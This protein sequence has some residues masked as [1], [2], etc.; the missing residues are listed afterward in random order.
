MGKGRKDE[1]V[2]CSDRQLRK[3]IYDL[4]KSE[5][6]ITVNNTDDPDPAGLLQIAR[7][8]FVDRVEKQAAERRWSPE[9]ERRI[10]GCI[11]QL[12]K[13]EIAPNCLKTETITKHRGKG[14]QS[15]VVRTQRVKSREEFRQVA[16]LVS[17]VPQFR[18]R[19]AQVSAGGNFSP[20]LSAASSVF[21]SAQ[22]SA[23]A[24]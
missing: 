2:G 4:V 11:S 3:T 5:G 15:E 21:S 16:V 20:P 18:T 17:L 22:S 13:F 19:L 1:G 12:V 24:D 23:G 8:H 6:V 9:R 14:K 10:V 7:E